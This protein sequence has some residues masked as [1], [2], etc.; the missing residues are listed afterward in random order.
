MEVGAV[1]TLQAEEEAMR[2]EEGEMGEV[3]EMEVAT[4]GGES[5]PA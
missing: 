2:V 3:E 1:K 5:S 4:E